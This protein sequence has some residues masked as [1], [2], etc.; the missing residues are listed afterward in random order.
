M[1]VLPQLPTHVALADDGSLLIQLDENLQLLSLDGERMFST[2]LS[3]EL[4]QVFAHRGHFYLQALDG[5]LICLNGQLQELW[6]RNIPALLAGPLSGPHLSLPCQ[7]GIWILEES[8]GRT[9]R[10]WSAE[11]PLL[12]VSFHRSQFVLVQANQTLA[13]TPGSQP[14]LLLPYAIEQLACSSSAPT[15]PLFAGGGCLAVVEQTAMLL[16]KTGKPRWRRDLPSPAVDRIHPV[17]IDG[18]AHWLVA[19]KSRTLSL[20]DG[21]G[22]EKTHIVLA[23]RPQR[24]AARRQGGYFLSYVSLPEISFFSAKEGKLTTHTLASHQIDTLESLNWIA[25]VG[26]DGRINFFRQAP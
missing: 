20:L 19:S 10:A 3:H 21:K 22:N 5:T 25:F 26:Y 7:S 24:L 12:H 17:A 6:R 1:Y 16:S 13:W 8:T 4:R 23:D 9:L 11:Q 2:G 15:V 18:K 14:K